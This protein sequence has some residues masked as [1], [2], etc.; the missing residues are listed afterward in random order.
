MGEVPGPSL[1]ELGE[2]PPAK[3]ETP[4]EEKQEYKLPTI[5]PSVEFRDR[6]NPGQFMY[7]ANY[8]GTVDEFAARARAAGEKTDR[9]EVKAALETLAEILSKSVEARKVCQD[10]K[11]FRRGG[12]QS[13]AS[14]DPSIQ[15]A[16]LALSKAA[17]GRTTSVMQAQLG[18]KDVV[19][20]L[21][22]DVPYTSA[23]ELGSPQTREIVSAVL[24]RGEIPDPKSREYVR[25][26]DRP[27]SLRRN[28][29]F[30]RETEVPGIRYYE[31]YKAGDLQGSDGFTDAA[32]KKRYTHFLPKEG[33]IPGSI[34]IGI[35]S[36][37]VEELKPK[38]E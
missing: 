22:F 9:P 24:G 4:A 34:S 19:D 2:V 12:D 27:D 23:I 25:E 6:S 36:E 5:Q 15:Q 20:A 30:N 33:A 7:A 35:D 21:G 13:I 14:Y 10:M 32:S 28:I 17:E 38:P 31:T 16:Y 1:E 8:L 29:S 18:H 37:S 3:I 11:T 26:I